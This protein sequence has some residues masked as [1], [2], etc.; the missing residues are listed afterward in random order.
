LEKGA[1][2]E[3]VLIVAFVGTI[4]FLFVLYHYV[5]WSVR[6]RISNTP[7]LMNVT[8]Q[9]GY[10]R[11]ID[12]EQ[13]VFCPR[14]A[15][16]ILSQIV[17][18]QQLRGVIFRDGS[19]WVVSAGK[20]LTVTRFPPTSADSRRMLTLYYMRQRPP[21]IIDDGDVDRTPNTTPP[22]EEIPNMVA[23][24]NSAINTTALVSTSPVSRYV[25]LKDAVAAFP[26]TDA[27]NE[28]TYLMTNG[29]NDPAF[30]IVR[31]RKDAPDAIISFA[32]LPGTVYRRKE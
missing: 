22:P 7:V 11:G 28:A 21:Q 24:A 1:M 16:D 3:S 17:L 9:A 6:S 15:Q 4:L 2:N 8:T 27:T 13:R 5:T 20:E 23:M 10:I 12:R 32:S 31:T 30:Y 14:K 25:S 19:V 26:V 29:P 18:Q